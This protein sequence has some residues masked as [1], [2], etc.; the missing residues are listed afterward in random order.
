M[1]TYVAMSGD[2][3]C[4][5]DYSALHSSRR[6]AADDLIAM[7]DIAGTRLAGTLRRDGI[8]YFGKR[9]HELGAQYA[10]IAE[11][12][13]MPRAEFDATCENWRC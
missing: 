2:P 12:D 7:L 9:S 1:R 11:G 5:P 3:G 4:L 13:N 10:E 6:A 8:V